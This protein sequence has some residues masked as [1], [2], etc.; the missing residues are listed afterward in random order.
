MSNVWCAILQ[1]QME[2][3]IG[4]ILLIAWNFEMKKIQFHRGRSTLFEFMLA[5]Y[6]FIFHVCVRWLLCYFF[7][8]FSCIVFNLIFWKCEISIWINKYDEN[9]FP[10]ARAKKKALTVILP[11]SYDKKVQRIWKK[12]Q[13]KKTHELDEFMAFA[14]KSN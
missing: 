6:S 13:N 9:D 8:L 1:T 3:I 14:Y 2:I 12:A 4:W 5:K 10:C 11:L 7:F